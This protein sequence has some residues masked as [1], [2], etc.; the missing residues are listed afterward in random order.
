LVRLP[1]GILKRAEGF[2]MKREREGKMKKPTTLMTSKAC[3]QISFFISF[4]LIKPADGSTC[5]EL[6]K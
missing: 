4:W 5:R 3:C 2:K 1:G 6:K